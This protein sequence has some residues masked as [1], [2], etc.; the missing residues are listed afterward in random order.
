MNA[1]SQYDQLEALETR[2]KD[3]SAEKVNNYP[4]L[5]QDHKIRLLLGHRKIL[6]KQ[7]IIQSSKL[8]ILQAQAELKQAEI[9]FSSLLEEMIAHYEI[10]ITTT[11]LDVDALKLVQ[12]TQ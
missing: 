2:S 7:N 11:S 1:P 3:D 8:T 4:E 10:D 6:S 9:E 12:K 5:A